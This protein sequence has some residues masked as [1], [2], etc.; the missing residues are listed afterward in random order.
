VGAQSELRR[1]V[2]SKLVSEVVGEVVVGEMVRA[3][4]VLMFYE[5]MKVM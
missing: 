1:K 3:P 4:R 5:S 2:I